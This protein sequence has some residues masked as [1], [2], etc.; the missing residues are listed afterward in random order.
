M[1]L[2]DNLPKLLLTT[3][4]F[5]FIKNMLQIIF[6]VITN[7]SNKQYDSLILIN[8]IN[9][10]GSTLKFYMF[11]FILYE[12]IIIGLSCYLVMYIFLFFIIKQFGNKIYIQILFPLVIYNVAIIFFNTSLDIFYL[13][14]IIILGFMNW[15]I[16]KKYIN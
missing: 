7:S 13:L 15:K 9:F 2:I 1:K 5:I 6:G 3:L 10:T 12:V 16:F 8:P 4:S 11:Y 14:I